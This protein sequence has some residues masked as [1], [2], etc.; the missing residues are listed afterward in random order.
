MT[1]P[2]FTPILYLKAG[3][4]HCLRLR[5][6]LLEADLLNRVDLHEFIPGTSGEHEVRGAL[7]GRLEKVTFPAAETAP[8]EVIADSAAIVAH[9]AASHGIDPGTLPTYTAYI[10]GIY[11]RYAQ[12]RR[13]LAALRQ[14]SD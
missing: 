12:C 4:P 14:G 3:C 6:F 7:E 1:S 10:D 9:L 2:A 8:G 13:E 11:A 5:L